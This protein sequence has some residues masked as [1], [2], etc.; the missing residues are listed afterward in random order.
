MNNS[1]TPSSSFNW[2]LEI[3]DKNPSVTL[4]I[5]PPIL[6]LDLPTRGRNPSG[7][8]TLESGLP[9]AAY[10]NNV[11]FTHSRYSL[12]AGRKL[13]SLYDFKIYAVRLSVLSVVYNSLNTSFIECLTAAAPSID[14]SMPESFNNLL[15][16]TLDSCLNSDCITLANCILSPIPLDNAAL[17]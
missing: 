4:F 3:R 9:I 16:I 14:T 11:L 1:S 6:C 8:T 13:G 10:F 7:I 15:S 2:V 17:W 12:C 5:P